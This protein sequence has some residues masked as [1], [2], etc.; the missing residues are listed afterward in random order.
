MRARRLCDELTSRPAV[1]PRWSW[2][3]PVSNNSWNRCLD[4]EESMRLWERYSATTE[5]HAARM[6]ER[7]L[8]LRYET[9]LARP[10]EEMTRVA[11]FA[12]LSPSI[13]D[14]EHAVSRLVREKSFNYRESPPLVALA[15]RHRTSLAAFGY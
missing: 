9:L 15:D 3:L 4:L 12:G 6:G 11:T 5:V 13:A 7:A 1:L 8:V 14:V 2:R 10:V